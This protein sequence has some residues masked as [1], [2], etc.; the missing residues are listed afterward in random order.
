MRVRVAVCLLGLGAAA[1]GCQLVATGTHNLL[2]DLKL[3][4]DQSAEHVHDCQLAK[5]IWTDI[6]ASCPEGTYSKDYAQGFKDGFVDYI[7]GGGSG[8]PPP[9]PPAHYRCSAYH[10][11]EG[12]KAVDDW[13]GGWRHGAAMAKQTGRRELVMTPVVIAPPDAG[14]IEPPGVPVPPGLPGPVIGPPMPTV[15]PPGSMAPPA[16]P[17]QLGPPTQKK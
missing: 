15:L 1:A 2:Y 6:V 5:K 4:T 10:T 7:E 14:H 13:F 16:P 12:H 9:F 8:D 11:F 17:E 3:C